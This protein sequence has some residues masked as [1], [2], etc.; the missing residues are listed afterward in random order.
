[1]KKHVQKFLIEDKEPL[2]ISQHLRFRK[3]WRW[4]DEVTDFFRERITNKYSLH[5]CCGQ[6]ELGDV[7]LDLDPSSKR[8]HEGD[9]SDIPFSIN[10]FDIVFGDWPWKMNF[11]K[12]WKPF[13]EMARVCKV[14][15]H[16]IV[17]ATWMPYAEST[18]LEETYL[19]CDSPF[20]TISAILVY[21]KLDDLK[22][23]KHRVLTSKELMNSD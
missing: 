7:R 19:R 23:K 21:R 15:G 13:Y 18:L 6:S 22:D 11:Y 5:V 20:G 4:N 9:M 8:T 2:P 10:T 14:D 17:N 1:M 12:R 16:I 3:S